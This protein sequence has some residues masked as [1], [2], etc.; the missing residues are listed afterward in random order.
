[1]L[2]QSC[3][4]ALLAIMTHDCK[5]HN[6]ISYVWHLTHVFGVKIKINYWSDF[7]LSLVNKFPSILPILVL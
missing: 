7:D 2:F 6:L 3:L 4:V 5:D 1:M